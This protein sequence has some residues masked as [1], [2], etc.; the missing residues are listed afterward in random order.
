MIYVVI[1]LMLGILYCFVLALIELRAFQK[2]IVYIGDLIGGLEKTLWKMEEI[3]IPQQLIFQQ[4]NT[5]P[6]PVNTG[7]NHNKRTPEQK[8]A[9]SARMKAAWIKRK[10][11]KS[12]PEIGSQ[13]VQSLS[14]NRV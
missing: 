7:G 14:P 12:I 1:I 2:R 3:Q 11:L 13:N 4:T 6:K 10:E 9:A 5:Q 8:A